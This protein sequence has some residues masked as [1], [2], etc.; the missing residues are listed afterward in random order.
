MIV[1]RRAGACGEL[2]FSGAMIRVNVRAQ[3]RLDLQ[4]A[5]PSDFDILNDLE[6]R[7][8]DRGAALAASTENVRG[9]T[10]L[11]SQELAK[12]HDGTPWDESV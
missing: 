9:A 2:A 7:I 5:F 4:P 3:D 11:G 12:N 6:L 10:G 1:D 8:D